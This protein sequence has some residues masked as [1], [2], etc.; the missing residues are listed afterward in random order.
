[1]ASRSSLLS[2]WSCEL[3]IRAELEGDLKG[4]FSGAVG[5]AFIFRKKV[6]LGY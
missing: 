1:V 6:A 5:E 3:A 2:P 4:G